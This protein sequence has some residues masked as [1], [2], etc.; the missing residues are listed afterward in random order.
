MW[1]TRLLS[2]RTVRA[3]ALSTATVATAAASAPSAPTTPFSDNSRA[4]IAAVSELADCLD[5]MFEK[6]NYEDEPGDLLQLHLGRLSEEAAKYGNSRFIASD[7][8][9]WSCDSDTAHLVYAACQ[10]SCLV[11]GPLAKSDPDLVPVISRAPSVTGTTKAVS[12]WTLPSRKALIVS[13]RGTASATDHMV[14]MNADA[15]DAG[16]VLGL[17]SSLNAHK[18]FLHCAQAL[19]PYLKQQIE[20]QLELNPDMEQVIFTGHS[21][22]GSVSSLIFLHFAHDTRSKALLSRQTLSLATFGAAPAVAQNVTDVTKA[23]PNV[24][25]MLSFVNEFD[26]V[27]RADQPYIRSIIDLYRARYGLP[28]RSAMPGDGA[29]DATGKTVALTAPHWTLPPPCYQLVGDIILSRK[30]T[31]VPTADDG[32]SEMTAVSSRQMLFHKVCPDDFY[33]LVFCDIGVHKRRTYLER[34]EH[35]YKGRSLDAE[36][37]SDSD[38][39]YTMGSRATTQVEGVNDALKVV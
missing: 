13:V 18:G 5:F 12:I 19:L 33:D 4:S 27:P 32:A 37:S 7:G 31:R 1:T 39:L 35:L 36:A 38:T 26:M 21:A 15:V 34:V 6:I 16:S 2:K 22:G 10:C 3:S 20:R 8:Q 30:T 11:Y 24:G 9:D 28:C 17:S 23:L 25:W 14:N 29:F